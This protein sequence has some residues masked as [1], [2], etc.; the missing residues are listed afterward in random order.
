M[1]ALALT[2]ALLSQACAGPSGGGLLEGTATVIDGD[3]LYVAE[4]EV[5]L[6]GIDAPEIG[7][8]CK[9]GGANRWRCGQYSTVALDGLAGGKQVSCK[10]RTTDSYGRAIAVCTR[11]GRDL[12]EQLVRRGW[13]LAYRRFSDRYVEAEETARDAKS[14]I[15][16]GEFEEPW[17]WRRRRREGGAEN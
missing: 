6:F 14:G 3:G 15:W 7:Q 8:Y 12:A 11:Q 2:L 9:R 1:A 17:H 10:V 4:T 5:R 13:A 16:S